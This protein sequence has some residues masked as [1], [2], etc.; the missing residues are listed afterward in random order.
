MAKRLGAY[1]H[2]KPGIGKRKQLLV[3]INTH[4]PYKRAGDQNL[5]RGSSSAHWYEA[6]ACF[7]VPGRFHSSWRDKR[8]CGHGRSMKGPTKAI[9]EALRDLSSIKR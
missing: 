9:Q 1:K 7:K 6:S 2:T 5:K 3:V 8:L 4:S